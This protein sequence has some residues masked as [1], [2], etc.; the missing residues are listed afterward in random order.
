HQ[1][2]INKGLKALQLSNSKQWE[3]PYLPIDPADV[4]RAYE[5]VIRI[6]SQSGKGGVAFVMEQ[7]HG[8]QLPRALQVEFSKIV[9]HAADKDGVEITPARIWELF[10]AAYLAEGSVVLSDYNHTREAGGVAVTADVTV[11]AKRCAVRGVGT[12]PI[13]AY[14]AALATVGVRIDVADYSEQAHGA[15]ANAEAVAYVQ[16]RDP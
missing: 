16:A 13:D 10:R 9:Q 5:P 6:N 12:G 15:G 4:G 2:A 8:L 14:V 11:G 7:D 3:V 1:D